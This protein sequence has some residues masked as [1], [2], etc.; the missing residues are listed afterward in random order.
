MVVDLGMKKRKTQPPS[1][2][3]DFQDDQ[4]ELSEP[5]ARMIPRYDPMGFNPVLLTFSRREKTD[6]QLA[7]KSTFSLI[8]LIKSGV[9]RQSLDDL[10][11]ATGLSLSDIADCMHMTERTLRNYTPQTRLGPEQS[12]RAIE[13]GKL[14]ELGSETFGSLAS[15]RSYMDSHVMALG[16]RKPKE[17]LD[18]SVG[19]EFLKD[20][21]GRIQHGVFA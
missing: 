14:Y 1:V 21:L 15:F 6:A 19:I 18:T 2:Q 10:M 11:L 3:Y 8:T 5:A 20:E 7:P 16:G 12:E 17:F 9:T 13:I 4:N